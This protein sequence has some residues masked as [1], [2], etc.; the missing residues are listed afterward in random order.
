MTKIVPEERAR[1]GRWGRH[2]LIILVAALLLLA[3]GWFAVEMYGES[4][5]GQPTQLQ[6]SS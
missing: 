3:V 4:I 1:Q 5:D 6:T 2:L